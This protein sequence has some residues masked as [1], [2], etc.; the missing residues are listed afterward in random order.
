MDVIQKTQFRLIGPKVE[1]TFTGDQH[2]MLNDLDI[3]PEIVYDKL[4]KLL[5]NKAPGV[6]HLSPRVLKEMAY[7]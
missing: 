6:D 2:E 4:C 7:L 1:H 3:T 5:P